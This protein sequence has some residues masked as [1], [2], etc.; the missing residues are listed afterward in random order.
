MGALA[1]D[2]E[3]LLVIESDEAAGVEVEVGADEVDGDDGGSELDE[4]GVVEVEV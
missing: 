1:A 4:H 3:M 2:D